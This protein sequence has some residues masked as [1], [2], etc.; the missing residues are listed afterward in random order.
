[1]KAIII[2]VF[3]G[4]ISFNTYSQSL[5]QGA[6]KASKTASSTEAKSPSQSKQSSKILHKKIA[7][8]KDKDAK[9]ASLGYMEIKEMNFGNVDKEGHIIDNFGS[10]LYASEVKYL[11]PKIYY[12]GLASVEKQVTF[13]VKIIKEDGTLESGTGSPY[14]YTYSYNLTVKPGPGQ[15]DVFNG[16]GTNSGGSYSSGLYNCEIW[17]N[18]NLIYQKNVRLYSGTTPLSEC[19]LFKMTSL[20]LGSEDKDLN[21]NVAPGSTLYEGEVKYLFGNLRCEGV[22][23]NDQKVTLYARIF[24]S[25]GS[26]SSGNNSPEGFTFKQALTITPGSNTHKLTG[27]GNDAGTIFKEGKHR[28]ELW[29]DGEKIYETN[30]TVYKKDSSAVY[31]SSALNDFFPIWGVTL[32]QT[33]WKQAKDLGYS[34]RMYEKGPDRVMDVNGISFWDHDGVGKFTSIYWLHYENDFPSSWKSKGFAWDKSYNSWLDVFRRLGFNIT[35]TKEPGIKKW[36][37]R[38]T[39]SASFKALSPDGVLEFE[40]NFSY[41]ENGCEVYSPKTLYSVRVRYKE[42]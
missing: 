13:Y 41:G 39:L 7:T 25:S 31:S 21:Q 14:G 11:K 3:L 10:N 40:L 22:Y 38:N 36:K 4:L 23:A 27:W 26:L 15:S 42:D 35:I 24:L 19:K 18:N 2:S 1:M 20:S 8:Q 34:V 32:G 28:Y 12:T 33:T 16:W 30:F 9:F 6:G 17:C 5:L 29:L 37:D